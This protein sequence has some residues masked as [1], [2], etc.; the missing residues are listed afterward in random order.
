MRHAKRLPSRGR[1]GGGTGRR[2]G[3]KILRPQGC[4]GS[5]PLLGSLSV[6]VLGARAH[7][8]ASGVRTLADHVLTTFSGGRA[9]PSAGSAQRNPNP[10]GR[11]L[12]PRPEPPFFGCEL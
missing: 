10:H 9:N 6:R 5:T 8:P 2:R 11:P 3:L 1:R 7:H 4:R 12:P